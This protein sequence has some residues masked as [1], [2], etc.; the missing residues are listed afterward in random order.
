MRSKFTLIR[1]LP[2]GVIVVA[3]CAR[4]MLGSELPLL[5]RGIRSVSA[6]LVAVVL[7]FIVSYLVK[8]Y[9]PEVTAV[10]MRVRETTIKAKPLGQ[11]V[12]ITLGEEGR[13]EGRAAPASAAAAPTTSAAP[14]SMPTTTTPTTTPLPASAAAPTIPPRPATDKLHREAKREVVNNPQH[15]ASIL[16]RMAQ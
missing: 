7:Y 6:S 4:G 11:R 3:L 13:G 10:R 1:A 14:M 12:D 8:R 16:R 15:A 5:Q 2:I 9:L